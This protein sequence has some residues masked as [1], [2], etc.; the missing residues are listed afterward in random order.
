MTHLHPMALGAVGVIL[1]LV[2]ALLVKW[3]HDR[4]KLERGIILPTIA[5]ATQ[6]TAT[7]TSPLVGNMMIDVPIMNWDGLTRSMPL[8]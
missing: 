3:R 6:V 7:S 4:F 8:K 5:P 1:L 2:V